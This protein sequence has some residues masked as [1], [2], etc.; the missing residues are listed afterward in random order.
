MDR[1]VLPAYYPRGQENARATARLLNALG[2]DFAI[3]GNEEK[4]AGECG[5]LI[6]EPGLFDTLRDQN[7]A[8][9]AKYE[10]ALVTSVPHAFDAFRYATRASASPPGGPH[11]PVP[12]H[13]S[14]G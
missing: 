2:V 11:H 4:C 13:T 10:F 14:T 8:T 3:L 9:F 7:M 1:G 6:W 5:R 12:G